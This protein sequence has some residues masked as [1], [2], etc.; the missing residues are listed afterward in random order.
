MGLI[1]CIEEPASHD[2]L[3]L[4]VVGV[5]AC[6]AAYRPVLLIVGVAA[7]HI[8]AVRAVFSFLRPPM[9]PFVVAARIAHPLVVLDQDH[10]G[11]AEPFE[12]LTDGLWLSLQ[13]VRD[14][15]CGLSAPPQ[16]HDPLLLL[17]AQWVMICHPCLPNPVIICPPPAQRRTPSAGAPS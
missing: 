15:L 8:V 10:P 4:P 16:H 14:L 6:A 1:R 7:A 9:L 11:I 3:V 5:V 2:L 13:F 17:S 12:P